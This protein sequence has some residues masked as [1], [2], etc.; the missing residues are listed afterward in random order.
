MH[1]DA[2][3]LADVQRVFDDAEP[4]DALT[5]PVYKALGG[6]HDE[7]TFR[8]HFGSWQR[9]LLE[10]GI[11]PVKEAAMQPRRCLRCERRFLSWGAA[12]RICN[13]CLDAHHSDPTPE[14]VATLQT[15]WVRDGWAH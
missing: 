13:R 15:G 2:A 14:P 6:K 9:V 12:N 4:W 3:L 8:Q 1:T 10:A 7:Q 11:L 5:F